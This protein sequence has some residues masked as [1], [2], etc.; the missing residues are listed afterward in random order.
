MRNR[1]LLFVLILALLPITNAAGDGSHGMS[2]KEEAAVVNCMKTKGCCTEHVP[3]I[4]M[5]YG[6]GH[7]TNF[8]KSL[9]FDSYRPSTSECITNCNNQKTETK[10]LQF[11]GYKKGHK[12]NFCIRKGYDGYRP[13]PKGDKPPWGYC[14][15]NK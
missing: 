5:G 13:A 4:W 8:C 1:M 3:I 6:G 10:P 9:G 11:L 15:K 14:Y 7:K 2:E 12:T